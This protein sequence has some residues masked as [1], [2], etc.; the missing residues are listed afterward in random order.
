MLAGCAGAGNA[1]TI[2]VGWLGALTGDSASW[3][4][5]ELNTLKMLFDEQNAGG[6]MTVGGKIYRFAL[7]PYDDRGIPE[8]SDAD[9]KKLASKDKVNVIIGPAFSREAIPVAKVA[10]WTKIPCI[11]TTATNPKVTQGIVGPTGAT[12]VNPYVFRACFID[13]YQGDVAANYAYKRLGMRKAAIF[14]KSDDEYS[15]GLGEYFNQNFRW[16]GGQVIASVSYTGDE[17]DFSKPLAGILAAKPD[18]VFA[19]VFDTDAALMARQARSMGITAVLMGGDGW[20]SSNLIPMGGSSLEGAYFINHLDV[21]DPA[22]QDYRVAYVKAYGKEP[23]L[24]GY[25]ANDAV[26]MFLDAL[27]RAQSLD[28]LAIA[29]ALETCDIQGITGHIKIGKNTHNPEGKDA[30]IIKIQGGKMVFQER[31]AAVTN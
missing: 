28:G 20:S 27:K 23:E 8:E 10:A 1:N 19:P 11:A 29:Q 30:A 15:V 22:V 7:F 4:Q 5:S 25:L 14:V 12:S 3:G 26:L 21:N 2:K 16:L 31:F 6:G 18:I 17:K 13:S 9:A 24:P